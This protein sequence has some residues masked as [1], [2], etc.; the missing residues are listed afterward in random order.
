MTEF[1]MQQVLDSDWRTLPR[2]IQKHYE[3]KDGQSSHLEGEMSIDYPNF[4]LPIV[5]L[6][7]Q[8]GGLIFRRGSAVHTHVRKTSSHT[9]R[10]LHW[11]RTMT[12]SG[13]KTGYFRSQMS[14]WSSRELIETTRFGFGLRLTI[15]AN[16]GDLIY[17]SN[18][19]FWQCSRFRLTIPDWLLLGSATIS[20]HALS[21]D[22]FYLD[23]TIRHPLW[24]ETYSYRGRF[25]YC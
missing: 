7:H 6:I 10:I 22:E 8:C 21:E 19:H 16:D 15:E 5:W 4:M 3:I 9:G 11:Q 2:V 12:Y 17:Q 18:G 23:F 20:E 13:G 25:R 1:L 24:G 14:C